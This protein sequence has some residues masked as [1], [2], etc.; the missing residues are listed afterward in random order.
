MTDDLLPWLLLVPLGATAIARPTD[1]GTAVGRVTVMAFAVATLLAGVGDLHHLALR[2]YAVAS[3]GGALFVSLSAGLLLGAMLPW[4][5]R[6]WRSWIGGLVLVLFA[7]WI[8][9][10][11]FRPGP[12]LLG[13]VLGAVPLLLGAALPG[14]APAEP[15]SVS[16]TS[17]RRAG[18]LIAA[19][20]LG[21][22]L[23]GSLV[24]VL[25]APLLALILGLA[26][27]ARLPHG[28]AQLLLPGVAAL[29]AIVMGWL[30]LTIAG[31]A[32]ARMAS[33]FTTAPVSPAAER[34][35]ALLAV[36][37]VL[38]TLA[39]WPLSRFGLGLALAPAATVLAHR[40]SLSV[41]PGAAGDWLPL[42]GM[43]LVPAAVIAALRGRWPE[44]LAIV[45][46]LAAWQPG[47][48][49]VAGAAAALLA[50][51]TLT[52]ATGSR[53]LLSPQRVT[54]AGAWWLATLA[55][56]GCAAATVAVLEHEVVL[57]TLLAAGLACAAARVGPTDR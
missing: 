32:M 24:A 45:A 43:V 21:L 48:M 19:V 56:L 38:A 37:V 31:D 35:L 26:V 42:L 17:S 16:P 50:A 12:Y 49:A 33:F 2:H 30:A 36:V 54:F 47:P 15:A 22:A 20:G 6:A 3:P 57:A 8:A 40:F 55:G 23:A 29:A 7:A 18:W 53:N 13:A 51:V 25:G 41:V 27:A 44:A 4:P 9:W 11:A 14:P 28:R 39:P 46:V 52:A 10:P 5:P 1:R 34:W